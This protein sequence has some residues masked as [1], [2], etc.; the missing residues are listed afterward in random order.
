[1]PIQS[2]SAGVLESAARFSAKLRGRTDGGVREQKRIGQ[3]RR[4]HLRAPF[5]LQGQRQSAYSR[6]HGRSSRHGHRRVPS[7][8]SCTGR[9][10]RRCTGGRARRRA[11]HA[12][13]YPA[14]RRRRGTHP[15]HS[16]EAGTYRT[17]C[18]AGSAMRCTNAGT[19]PKIE[20]TMPAYLK[21]PIRPRFTTHASATQSLA[22]FSSL[23][24]LCTRR[25]K[26]QSKSAIAISS[27]TYTGSPHA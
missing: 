8:W 10:D 22:F 7:R 3:A 2:A 1:M 17:K 26:Y 18:R 24:A 9:W 11:A 14:P 12:S 16:S 15:Q 21:K 4:R 19:S 23:C 25:A 6:A 20:Q 13:I 27:S 5:S